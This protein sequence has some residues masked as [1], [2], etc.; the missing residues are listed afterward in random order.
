MDGNTPEEKVEFTIG[1]HVVKINGVAGSLVL[2]PDESS[3]RDMVLAAATLLRE[4]ELFL[5]HTSNQPMRKIR[6]Q[7]LEDVKEMIVRTASNEMDGT[8][9]QR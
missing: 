9:Y 3:P 1:V 8:P 6:Q 4:F 5:G 2:M 7:V